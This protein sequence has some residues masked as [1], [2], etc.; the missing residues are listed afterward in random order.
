MMMSEEEKTAYQK[1]YEENKEEVSK[2]RKDK[3]ENDPEYR[4][5]RK[6]EAQRYYWLKKRRAKSLVRKELDL[7]EVELDPDDYIEI[8]ISNEDDVRYG[9][10]V[11]VPVY[12]SRQV[13]DFLDRTAQTVRLWYKNEYLEDYALRN[14]QNY[15]MY[16]EDQMKVLLKNRHLLELTVKDFSQHP[17]FLKVN[18]GWEE[19]EP[20]GIEPMP[21]DKWRKDPSQCPWCGSS[22][23]LQRKT[24]DGEWEHVPC[25][26]CE[27]P[28]NVEDRGE[29]EEYRVHGTCSSCGEGIDKE[30][31]TVGEKIIVKCP[32]CD[33][34][35]S[36]I[37]VEK[38]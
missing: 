23:A 28:Y 32:R 24:E 8:V 6:R 9:M 18:K 22:P 16:T 35:V 15:R 37:D 27:D 2:S 14:A 11:D 29:L 31:K 36:D 7:E 34:R 30:I 13:T 5:K 21:E 20:D 3:Y 12:M 17:F 26:K 33:T 10:T 25:L 19:L 1:W 38:L 4:K